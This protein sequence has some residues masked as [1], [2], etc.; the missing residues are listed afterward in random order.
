MSS[1]YIL[2]LASLALGSPLTTTNLQ[3]RIPNSCVT[4]TGDTCVFPFTYL[5]VTHSQCTYSDSP[6]P[7]CATQTDSEGAV[8]TNKWG[9]C[10]VSSLSSCQTESLTS[11]SCTTESGPRPAQSCV[12]PFRHLGITYNACTTVG[13][14]APWCSTTTTLAGTHVEGEYGFCPS[15]CPLDAASPPPVTSCTPGSVFQEDCNTCVCSPEGEAICSTLV[16]PGATTSTTTSTT[17]TTT[18]TTA[19]PASCSTVSGPAQGASCIFPFTYGG[20]TH[21][22]CA[23]WVYGG[24]H[25]GKFWCSTK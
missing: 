1:L 17:T 22:T 19:P 11:P 16:C 25:Q 15:S 6:T 14:L 24:E 3:Q 5:G 23:E 20:E 8:V 9:D 10:Q 7:W 21:S 2:S 4:R 12:F 13:E 18:T